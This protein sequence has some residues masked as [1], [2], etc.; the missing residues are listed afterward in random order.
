MYFCQ[1]YFSHT[2]DGTVLMCYF[3][4]FVAN[5]CP[6][7]AVNS[8]AVSISYEKNSAVCCRVSFSCLHGA[9]TWAVAIT[10]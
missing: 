1:L 5:F 6:F 10:G 3:V 9:V 4:V 7:S 2:V 8:Y